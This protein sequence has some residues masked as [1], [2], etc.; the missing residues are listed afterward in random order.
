M[1]TAERMVCLQRCT[2]SDFIRKNVT[3]K[4]QRAVTVVES[5]DSSFFMEKFNIYQFYYIINSIV[6]GTT[7]TGQIQYREVTIHEIR[8][9]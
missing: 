1:I 8:I 6:T 4:M 7:C 9:F 5:V 3:Y 2:I